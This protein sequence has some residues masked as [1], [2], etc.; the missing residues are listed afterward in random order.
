[1]LGHEK[2]AKTLAPW[3]F[4]LAELGWERR[5][6]VVAGLLAASAGIRAMAAVLVVLSVLLA[7]LPA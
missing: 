1:M 2:R 7:L 3:P 6:D 4:N 5:E